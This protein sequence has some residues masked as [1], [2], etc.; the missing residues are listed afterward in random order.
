VFNA[1]FFISV[2]VLL[3]ASMAGNGWFATVSTVQ[4]IKQ[5]AIALS[6]TERDE[7]VRWLTEGAE[8]EI[9]TEGQRR[10]DWLRQWRALVAKTNAAIGVISWK[11]D[12]LYEG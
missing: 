9:L 5:A 7:L 12:E 8:A 4:E 6:A 2:S 10:R 3:L 1:F 11:R